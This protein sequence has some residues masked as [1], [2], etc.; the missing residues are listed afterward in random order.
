MPC[1]RLSW[2]LVRFWAHVNIVV[3]IGIGRCDQFCPWEVSAEHGKDYTVFLQR[4]VT[5]LFFALYPVMK[6]LS[7]VMLVLVVMDWIG[8]QAYSKT[9][10]ASTTR[11]WFFIQRV[12]NVWNNLPQDIVDF[13]S[14]TS[15]QRTIKLDNCQFQC[16]SQSVC[17]VIGPTVF[18]L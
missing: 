7:L 6:C 4:R 5:K 15:F 13:T 1:G 9:Y 8:L 11:Y 18:I 3:G 16:T 2:L 12:I 17:P 14:I 10:C